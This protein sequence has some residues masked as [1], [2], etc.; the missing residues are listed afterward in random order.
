M[1]IDNTRAGINPMGQERR[2]PGRPPKEVADSVERRNER[3][4]LG[5]PRLKL[6]AEDRPGYQR[7]W[8]NDKGT[9]IDDALKAGYQFVTVDGKEDSSDVG[10]RI[11]RLVGVQEGGQPMRAYLME[12]PETW[13][14]E[15]QA[16]KQAQIDKIDSQIRR[17]EPD[18]QKVGADGRYV[19]SPG[20][21]I[22]PARG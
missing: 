9:R 5:V 6:Q 16:A 11:S 2:G 18:G 20:I 19:P 15:D 12:I 17:G 13:Y 22:G 21:K 3:V 4:P 1:T 10:N 8:L 14:R 7:R